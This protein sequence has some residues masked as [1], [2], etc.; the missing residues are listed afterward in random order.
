MSRVAQTQREPF[1]LTTGESPT[2]CEGGISYT[3]LTINSGAGLQPDLTGHNM[4]P[5]FS[6]S[7]KAVLL[8]EA[9][10]ARLLALQYKDAASVHD[11]FAYAD[12]LETAHVDAASSQVAPETKCSTTAL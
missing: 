7:E 1:F 5:G 8:E 11:L 12:A 4:F 9:A 10:D 3:L 6:T 2:A